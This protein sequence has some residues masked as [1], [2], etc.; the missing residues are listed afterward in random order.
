MRMFRV[1][2]VFYFLIFGEC[3]GI[4]F[5]CLCEDGRIESGAFPSGCIFDRSSN[6]FPLCGE[7]IS[8]AV[9]DRMA[10]C[11]DIFMASEYLSAN[12]HIPQKPTL[13]LMSNLPLCLVVHS[14]RKCPQIN[15]STNGDS[16]KLRMIE[17]DTVCLRI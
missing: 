14:L 16:N 13:R 10:G 6:E 2:L 7:G 5:S 15:S 17:R 1:F 11:S 3:F 9:T 4:S 12:L 8:M